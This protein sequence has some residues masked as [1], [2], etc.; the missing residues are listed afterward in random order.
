M[1]ATKLTAF[2][3]TAAV[4]VTAL[5]P[6]VS[7]AKATGPGK[8]T[9]TEQAYVYKQ[10]TKIVDGTVFKG[11]TIKVE[12]LSKN[13]KYA[14]GLVYGHVNRH[15]WVDASVLTAKKYL[16]P[17]RASRSSSESARPAGRPPWRTRR[18]R[19]CG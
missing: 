17:A 7:M 19:P 3:A 2:A 8:Y 5:A 13:G 16:L 6:A 14:Y 15:A 10:P 1:N 18:R 4:A 12:K 9:V 11:N